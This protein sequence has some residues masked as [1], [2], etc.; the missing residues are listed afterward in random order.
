MY[1]YL[2]QYKLEHRIIYRIMQND[3]CQN[4]VFFLLGT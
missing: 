2:T 1:I 3:K 4:D